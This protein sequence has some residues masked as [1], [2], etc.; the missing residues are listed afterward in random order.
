VA[1]AGEVGSAGACVAPATGVLT[2]DK[3][4]RAA[5]FTVADGPE[6]PTVGNAKV[7]SVAGVS[8]AAGT[9]LVGA[10]NAVCVSWPESWA[11]VVPT[12]AVFIALRSR[13]GAGVAPTLHDVNSKAAANK[14]SRVCRVELLENI[15]LTSI[16]KR[17]NLLME[18]SH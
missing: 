13:V 5:G 1:G 18:S 12:I 6:L 11:T 2:N 15:N 14:S 9:V 7:G 10:A 3:V 17:L 4:G 16:R 8:V